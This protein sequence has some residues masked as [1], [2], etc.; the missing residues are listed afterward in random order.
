[1]KYSIDTSALLDGWRRYYPPDIFPPLW[2]RLE[3]LI[4]AGSLGAT[5]EVLHELQKKDDGVATWAQQNG[6]LFVPIDHEVQLAL[7]DILQR[8]ERL[9]N[10]QRN[11]SM[12]DPWVIALAHVRNCSVVTG[13]TPSGSLKR[14]KIPDVCHAL[15]I[16]C[17][18][19]LQLFREEGW[20]FRT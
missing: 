2:A 19:L 14:P 11:R 13:E 5:E 16:P 7:A 1:M 8:F 18:N 17:I 6:T 20:V 3:E 9:V 15:E 10:T 4:R 12:A